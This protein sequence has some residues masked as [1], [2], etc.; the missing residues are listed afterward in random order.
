M[1]IEHHPHQIPTDLFTPGRQLNHDLTSVVYNR[2]LLEVTLS[3]KLAGDAA[4]AHFIQAA[5]NYYLAQWH[6][7][8][9][10]K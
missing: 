7:A 8:S 5:R 6:G 9:L 2:P 4:Q 10:A 1:Q 3:Q